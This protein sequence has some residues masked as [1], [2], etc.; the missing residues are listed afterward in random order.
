VIGFAYV[1]PVCTVEHNCPHPG[2][3][4]GIV[5]LG[6]FIV[7]LLVALAGATVSGIALFRHRKD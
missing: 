1:V 7:G 2:G 6:L 5:L 3:V 4:W